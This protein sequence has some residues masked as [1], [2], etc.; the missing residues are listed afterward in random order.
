MPPGRGKELDR[1]AANLERRQSFETYPPS[2]EAGR[3]P[4]GSLLR[5]VTE[6]VWKSAVLDIQAVPKET[7]DP[8][9]VGRSSKLLRVQ[10]LEI[11]LQSA[12][13]Y[14][15]LPPRGIE[16]FAAE[17]VEDIEVDFAVMLFQR[18]HIV[19]CERWTGDKMEH[20]C[21]K[22]HGNENLV[23]EVLENRTITVSKRT[24]KAHSSSLS[25]RGA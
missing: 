22:V 23:I 19:I 25:C 20:L 12:F 11:R 6:T 17:D 4:L 14:H 1:P 24:F 15:H 10:P 13:A 3:S 2:M 5:R 7:G 8:Q 21:H 9:R 16:C 18:L